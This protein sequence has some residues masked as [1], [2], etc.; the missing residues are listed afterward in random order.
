MNISVKTTSRPP[1]AAHAS[2]QFTWYHIM[3]FW[4]FCT[5]LASCVL[6]K[7]PRFPEILDHPGRAS[8]KGRL[9]R[10]DWASASSPADNPRITTGQENNLHWPWLTRMYCMYHVLHV[11]HCQVFYMLYSLVQANFIIDKRNHE[12]G[13]VLVFCCRHLKQSSMDAHHKACHLQSSI[14]NEK[15]RIEAG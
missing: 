8:D 4:A 9:G 7:I 12:S 5:S 3:G 2:L 10:G 1:G 11:F 6:P 14:P 15:Q 13:F